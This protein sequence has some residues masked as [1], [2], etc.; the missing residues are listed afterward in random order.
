MCRETVLK[1]DTKRNETIYLQ[2]PTS[3]R[4]PESVFDYEISNNFPPGTSSSYKMVMRHSSSQDARIYRFKLFASTTHANYA[5]THRRHL[6]KILTFTTLTFTFPIW[7]KVTWY[8]GIT[9]YLQS[10]SSAMSRQQPETTKSPSNRGSR[11]RMRIVAHVWCFLGIFY[12]VFLDNF[13]YFYK[14]GS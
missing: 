10:S 2:I 9:S 11:M 1:R 3:L 4:P 6:W 7:Y 8:T 12:D 14:I 5:E 13:F